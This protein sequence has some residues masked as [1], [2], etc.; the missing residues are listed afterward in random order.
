[1]ISLLPVT[2]LPEV[3]AGTE[4]AELVLACAQLQERDVLVITQ[5]VV[6]KAEGRLVRC[7]AAD[8]AARSQ[9]VQA[10]SRRVL[11]ERDGMAITETLHG[12]VCANAGIDFSNVPEGMA[13]LLPVD[14]DRS[15]RH[16]R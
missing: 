15:A 16:I 5:K 12:F 13:A 2:G 3:A 7:D 11:R 9:L 8:P 1:M 6:S 10:Q 4:I 14:P